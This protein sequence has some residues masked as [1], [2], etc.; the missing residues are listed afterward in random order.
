MI[1]GADG[2]IYYKSPEEEQAARD[3][4]IRKDFDLDRELMAFID[5]MPEEFYEK[6]VEAIKHKTDT[7]TLES[8]ANMIERR[9]DYLEPKYRDTE[10]QKDF[11]AKLKLTYWSLLE[12]M[13]KE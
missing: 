6:Y 5:G 13:T 4:R 8:L 12:E 3:I 1:E 9:I 10:E 7:E 2:K 11:I